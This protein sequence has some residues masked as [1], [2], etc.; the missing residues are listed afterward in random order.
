M[1]R[2]PGPEE[3]GPVE[4]GPVELLFDALKSVS[5]TVPSDRSAGQQEGD[6]DLEDFHR[7]SRPF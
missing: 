6:D 1:I 4:L 5:P 2:L 7:L 3:L